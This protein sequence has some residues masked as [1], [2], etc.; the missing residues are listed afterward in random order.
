MSGRA[1]LVGACRPAVTI[2]D[3]RG[4]SYWETVL[5]RGALRHHG[6][7]SRVMGLEDAVDHSS[8]R[9]APPVVP[10]SAPPNAVLDAP[11]APLLLVVL[12]PAPDMDVSDLSM[13]LRDTFGGPRERVTVVLAGH[14]QTLTILGRDAGA[15]PAPHEIVVLGE[16]QATIARL[17]TETAFLERSLGRVLVGG[18]PEARHFRAPPPGD[19][20][21][22]GLAP[23]SP[24]SLPVLTSLGC[25]KR[26]GYCTMASTRAKLYRGGIPRRPRPWPD[27]LEEL[28]GFSDRGVDGF[29]LLADQFLAADPARNRD[30]AELARRW[31]SVR[32]RRPRLTFTVAPGEVVRNKNLLSEMASAFDLRPRLS[33]DSLD[34][35]TLSLLD[36]DFDPPAAIEA[37]VF[38][39]GLGLPTRVNYIFVRPGMTAPRLRAEL[40]RLLLVAEATAHLSYREKLVLGHDIFSRRL[41]VLPGT[42]VA[43]KGT[44]ARYEGDLP[45]EALRVVRAVQEAVGDLVEGGGRKDHPLAVAVE[46]GIRAL[47][48]GGGG[49]RSP[50]RR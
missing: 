10:P 44:S 33:V 5:I 24:A 42:P 38:L 39:E 11:P 41:E 3:E 20:Q 31:G 12:L 45:V 25:D 13:R 26:C 1:T 50:G 22:A 6:L 2:V 48:G 47:G 27:L 46:A 18:R 4:P 28:A 37:L 36:L 21:A 7:A 14:G 9:D 19:G 17:A 40:S 34:D 32:T 49:R 29:Q 23:D 43:A 35:Q 16:P 30:L 8:G 15:R